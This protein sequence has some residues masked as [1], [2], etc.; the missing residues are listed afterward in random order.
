MSDPR[1]SSNSADSA[2]AGAAA[3]EAVDLHRSF[4]I[5]SRTIGVLRGIDLR[6]QPGEWLALTGPS[7]SGKTT[8]LHLLAA[9]D[10]PTSGDVRCFGR[11]Y[12]SMNARARARI[13]RDVIGLLFQA[14]HLFPELNALENVVLPALYPGRDKRAAVEKARSLLDAFGLSHRERHRPQELSGGEQQRIALARALINDPAILLADEPTGN[15]DA[16]AADTIME[17]LGRLHAEGRT[18]VMATHD[19][20][21]AAC[22]GRI[23]RLADGRLETAKDN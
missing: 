1:T 4:H 13:R 2:N 22:A 23:V 16:K 8:L 12:Q 7:G 14:F 18:I 6:V 10:L 15:L 20:R 3:L 21:L 5:E 9:L 17:I 19:M 11:S